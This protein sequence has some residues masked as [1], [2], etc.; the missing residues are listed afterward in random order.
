L[1][2]NP[3]ASRTVP[4][5]SKATGVA[6]AKAAARVMMGEGHAQRAT[7][8]TGVGPR[9]P[10][11][12]CGLRLR[13][14]LYL[15]PPHSCRLLGGFDGTSLHLPHLPFRIR[16]TGPVRRLLGRCSVCFNILRAHARVTLCRPL[17]HA[18]PLEGRTP[19]SGREARSAL[20][21]HPPRHPRARAHEGAKA[22]GTRSPALL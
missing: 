7:A 16:P 12:A 6:V 21:S 13:R 20:H 9:F 3:R 14:P 5:V 8:R 15:E 10:P 1:E 17:R 4:F 2:A 19:P 18:A 22:V 11:R